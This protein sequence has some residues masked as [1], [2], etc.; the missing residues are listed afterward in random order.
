MGKKLSLI[1]FIIAFFAMPNIFAL[2]IADLNTANYDDHAN[3]DT[4]SKLIAQAIADSGADIIALQEIRYNKKNPHSANGSNMAEHVLQE[5]D[6]IDPDK[7]K[8]ADL[9]VHEAMH[10]DTGEDSEHWE[11]LSIIYRTND[12]LKFIKEGMFPLTISAICR[13]DENRR[14][15][16]YLEFEY[17]GHPLY[18]FNTHFSYDKTCRD[19]NVSQAISNIKNTVNV[20]ET[21]IL[22][23]GD[24]NATDVCNN[25]DTCREYDPEM[26]SQLHD[27]GLIDLWREYYDISKN[28][29][30]TYPA[31]DPNIRIDYAW[32]NNAFAIL[33]Q[34]IS[35]FANHS[36][37]NIYPSDHYGLV[38][39]SNF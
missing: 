12:H 2:K 19:E 4:R 1:L 3:W 25:A 34:G 26:I 18:I 32:V 8:D 6:K 5:L 27:N 10:Y 30:Y 7:F 16:Q 28:A 33:T 39:D 38:I 9:S 21:P 29:G 17:D 22:L 13:I 14:I 11:G 15:L 31:K 36:S 37:G 20:N 24:L 23:V 35:I